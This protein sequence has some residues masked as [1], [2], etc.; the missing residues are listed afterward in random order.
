MNKTGVQLGQANSAKGIVPARCKY[1]FVIQ[2]GNPENVTVVVCIRASG[3]VLPP[4]VISK[5]AYHQWGWYDNTTPTDWI[6]GISPKGWT[7]E[8]LCLEWLQRIFEEQYTKPQNKQYR[9]LLVDGHD[10]HISWEFIEYCIDN[11]DYCAMSTTS[12]VTTFGCRCFQSASVLLR[13]RSR[14]LRS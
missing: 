9:L 10:S 12:L 13:Y 3:S 7:D 4:L 6:I 8:T 5:G 11:K 2:D 14:L 1:Q